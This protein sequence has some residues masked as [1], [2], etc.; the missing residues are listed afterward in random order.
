MS[1]HGRVTLRAAGV[2]NWY[3]HTGAEPG[4]L[5]TRSAGQCSLPSALSTR[6][7]DGAEFFRVLKGCLDTVVAACAGPPGHEQEGQDRG[8]Q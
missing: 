8:E 6:L 7:E 3:Q 1:V 2:R 4:G 5:P